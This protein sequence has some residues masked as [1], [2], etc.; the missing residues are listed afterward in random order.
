[1]LTKRVILNLENVIGFIKQSGGSFNGY[2]KPE[3]N[4]KGFRLYKSFIWCWL[5]SSCCTEHKWTGCLYQPGVDAA[6]LMTWVHNAHA[7]PA[8]QETNL[9]QK[10]E[11]Q[12]RMTEIK[13]DEHNCVLKYSRKVISC[14]THLGIF[15]QS[16]Y[17]I[18]E[19]LT[20]NLCH[21]FLYYSITSLW[22]FQ[23]FLWKFKGLWPFVE[24]SFRLW[25]D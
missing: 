12:K 3:R 6:L 13:L 14:H 8:K 18:N 1:M 21:H 22:Q 15:V 10:N 16:L 24:G 7:L 11:E 5:W 23:K 20:Y 25:S 19:Y 17:L 9:K 4:F 2:V